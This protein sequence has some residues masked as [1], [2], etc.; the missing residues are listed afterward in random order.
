MAYDEMTAKLVRENESLRRSL[1]E[2][3]DT[4]KTQLDSFGGEAWIRTLHKVQTAEALLGID[5]DTLPE[6]AA[7]LVGYFNDVT[8]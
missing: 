7:Q 4:L 2:L 5:S 1:R 8:D 3:R 6:E